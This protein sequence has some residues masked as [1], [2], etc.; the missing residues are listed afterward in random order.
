MSIIRDMRKQK[1]VYWKQGT[2]LDKFGR[3]SWEEPVEIDCRWDDGSENM[4]GPQGET[5]QFSSTVYVDREMAVGD[6]LKCGPLESD[7]VSDPREDKDAA[8][9]QRF[10]KNPNFQNTETLYTAF[11]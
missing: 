10:A 11:L 4:R 1:A 6:F 5:F 8:S 7:T 3:V 9:I 2:E